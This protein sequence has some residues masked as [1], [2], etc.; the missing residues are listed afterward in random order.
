MLRL[1]ELVGSPLSINALREDL[2]GHTQDRGEL[3]AR[4]ACRFQSAVRDISGS[5]PLRCPAHS[6][7]EAGTETSPLGLE[8][9]VRTPFA[10][11][12]RPGTSWRAI[13]NWVHHDGSEAPRFVDLRYFRDT[14]R[15]RGR[16]RDRRETD[17]ANPWWSAN[18]RTSK[19]IADSGISRRDFRSVQPGRYRRQSRVGA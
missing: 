16:L 19:S 14:D 15:R 2:A 3:A 13:S 18:G 11:M 1:P 10:S 4:S 17:A 8:C 12:L 5:S 9:Y 6:R 7:G